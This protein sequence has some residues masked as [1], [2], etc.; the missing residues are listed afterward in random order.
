M[1]D[2]RGER[3]SDI[4]VLEDSPPGD[5]FFQ[6]KKLVIL[7]LGVFGTLVS[8]ELVVNDLVKRSGRGGATD[9]T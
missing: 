1:G 4:S 9:I 2:G 6:V 3:P 5:V 8:I 7:L